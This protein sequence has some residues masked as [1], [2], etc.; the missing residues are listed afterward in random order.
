VV[1]NI[2]FLCIIDLK[3]GGVMLNFGHK[4]AN[5]EPNRSNVDTTPTIGSKNNLFLKE[6]ICPI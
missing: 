3:A 1:D 4:K 2:M 5:R 6:V